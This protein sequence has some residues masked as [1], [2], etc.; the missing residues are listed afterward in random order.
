MRLVLMHFLL[1]ILACS[2]L[3]SEKG[4]LRFSVPDRRDLVVVSPI[5]AGTADY[6]FKTLYKHI[7]LPKCIGCHEGSSAKPENDPIDLSSYNYLVEDR[8][9]PILRPGE[10]HKS[11][12]FLSTLN[13]EMPPQAP[14][15]PEEVLYIKNWIK[16]CAPEFKEQSSLCNSAPGDDEPSDD[17]P[18]DDEP[19]DDEPSDDEP[20]DDEPSDD[21]PSDDEPE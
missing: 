8:F 15:E 19:S 9:I 1:F 2:C 5:I 6:D 11:R 4:P 17:E 7:L 18:S 12:L 13:N 16:K 3:S 14:L 10:P 20:S 21:E